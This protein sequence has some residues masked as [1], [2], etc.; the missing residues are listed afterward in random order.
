MRSFSFAILGQHQVELGEHP[1]T[2]VAPDRMTEIHEEIVKELDLAQ[3]RKIP[4]SEVV[5]TVVKAK[6]I[7]DKTMYK[8]VL[9]FN[10]KPLLRPIF[11]ELG[12]EDT[13][14]SLFAR[15]RNA[16]IPP[17]IPRSEYSDLYE[18]LCNER[19]IQAKL[20]I[21]DCGYEVNENDR[22]TQEILSYPNCSK[23]RDRYNKY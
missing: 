8:T 4:I 23:Y 9:S 7:M 22:E 14:S 10:D 13:T 20:L 18:A 12:I 2:Y 1:I 11:T 17:S 15:L 5:K 6:E 3:I 19:P 16:G 21:Y